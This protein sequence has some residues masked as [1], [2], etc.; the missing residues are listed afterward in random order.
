V[1]KFDNALL[2]ELGLD[3][4]PADLKKLMFK[5]I[6]A[7]LERRVGTV[8]AGQMTGEQ[9]DEF[10]EIIKENKE[11]EGV[12][13]LEANC[14]DYKETVNDEFRKLKDE[15]RTVSPAILRNEGIASEAPVVK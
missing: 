8:L 11:G 5:Q 15:I 4:L 14:P 13:W 12:R 6:R 3:A 2:A 1:I 10:E 9:L 7:T